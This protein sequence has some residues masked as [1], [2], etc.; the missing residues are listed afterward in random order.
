[1]SKTNKLAK[2][3][4]PAGP[5]IKTGILVSYTGASATVNIDGSELLLPMLD[6]ISTTAPIGSTVVCSVNGASGYI[7]GTLNNT[8]RTASGSYTGSY[9]NPP[10]PKPS[11]LGYSYTNFMPAQVG[12]FNIQVVP[13]TVTSTTT[14]FANGNPGD[15]GF[16]FYGTNA[17][18][19]LT[20][21]NIQS[22]EVYMSPLLLDTNT[23]PL[24]V[25]SHKAAT[26]PATT[27]TLG[28]GSQNSSASGW[29]NLGS[30]FVNEL[31]TSL[32]A[33]GVGFSSLTTANLRP[34]TPYGTL[35]VGWTN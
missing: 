29:V 24:T 23:Y 32:T 11:N 13:F 4:K 25:I 19:S 35:R 12:T 22:V 18:S 3:L 28:I 5:K 14:L 7:I 6:S 34:N 16:W 31:K 17:F 27:F 8:S 33:W 1:M 20:G 10:V 26:R 2:Q 21:K 9:W 15:A 30:D